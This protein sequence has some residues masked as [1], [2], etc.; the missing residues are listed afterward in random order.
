MCQFTEDRDELQ[1]LLFPL[2]DGT[3]PARRI[4]R[5]KTLEL[6]RAALEAIRAAQPFTSPRSQGLSRRARPRRSLR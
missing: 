3:G 4:S 6:V 1:G 2:D 5:Q